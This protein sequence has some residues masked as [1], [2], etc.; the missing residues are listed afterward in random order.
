LLAKTATVDIVGARVAIC[1]QGR[2]GLSDPEDIGRI[3]SILRV[4]AI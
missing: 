4:V 3:D 2:G 1:G